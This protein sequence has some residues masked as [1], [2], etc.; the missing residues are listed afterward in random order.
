LTVRAHAKDARDK[1]LE[2]ICSVLSRFGVQLSPIIARGK[3][4]GQSYPMVSVR[5]L[6]ITFGFLLRGSDSAGL[7]PSKR[8]RARYGAFGLGTQCSGCHE[9]KGTN[10]QSELFTQVQSLITLQS[11]MIR[12]HTNQ[13]L[14]IDKCPPNLT[15]WRGVTQIF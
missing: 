7:R 12:P 10:Y 15:A 14:V 6:L 5:V 11:A 4:K 1:P 2:V 13:H 8:R 3:S 9:G